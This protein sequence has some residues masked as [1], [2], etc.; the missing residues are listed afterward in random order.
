MG[1]AGNSPAI[2]F[3]RKLRPSWASSTS[4]GTTPTLAWSFTAISPGLSP[5]WAGRRKVR[6]RRRYALRR[7]R[8]RGRPLREQEPL[9]E[10]AD[11]DEHK[12]EH[13]EGE[14]AKH[15]G[16]ARHVDKEHLSD[17][18]QDHRGRGEPRRLRAQCDAGE[19]QHHAV[20]EP[21]GRIGVL[22]G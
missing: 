9:V 18:E 12:A 2:S 20:G 3:L 5:S 4:I 22:L 10:P 21:Y 11:A 1:G 13:D 15:A 8:W 17:G 7:R 14:S 16:N 19:Q 6:R